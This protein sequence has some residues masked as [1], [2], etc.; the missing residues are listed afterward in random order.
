MG[1]L[2]RRSWCQWNW[3]WWVRTN[4]ADHKSMWKQFWILMRQCSGLSLNR[5]PCQQNEGGQFSPC[6]SHVMEIDG[7]HR[8]II[9]PGQDSHLPADHSYKSGFPKMHVNLALSFCV[10]GEDALSWTFYFPVI[11]S[12]RQTSAN[13]ICL[14][15]YIQHR[16]LLSATSGSFLRQNNTSPKIREHIKSL[17][18][19]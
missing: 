19:H 8:D 13:K 18:S 3:C 4:Q 17:G 1:F 2:W 14:T 9:G 5:Q 7:Q 10:T 15:L 12:P 6:T 16:Q 11:H